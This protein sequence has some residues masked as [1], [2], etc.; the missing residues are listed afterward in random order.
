M[1]W[2]RVVQCE[3]AGVLNRNV[4]DGNSHRQSPVVC[5]NWDMTLTVRAINRAL[6]PKT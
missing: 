6:N 2:F 4:D 5:A 3:L 1:G